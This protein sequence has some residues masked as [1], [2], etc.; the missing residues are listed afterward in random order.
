MFHLLRASVWIAL[1][2]LLLPGPGG[3]LARA[4][5]TC[6]AAG[7][8]PP[9][10]GAGVCAYLDE[11]LGVAA[12][13]APVQAGN[14]VDLVTGNKY[15]AEPDLL[16]DA[17]PPQVLVR[18]Y[19]SLNPHTGALGAGWSH[20][21]E[22]R[23]AAV[24]AGGRD[25]LQVLQGDGRRLVFERVRSGGSRWRTP[26]PTDGELIGPGP[27][28]PRA[29]RT[30]HRA[31]GWALS[32]RTDGQ[33]A[34]LKKGDRPVLQLHY[35]AQ[36][37][38]SAVERPGAWRL[39]V[40]WIAHRLGPRLGAAHLGGKTV[41]WDYDPTGQLAA[42]HWPD[43]RTQHYRYEDLK[44]PLR[45]TSVWQS[46][47]GTGPAL[48]EVA[49]YAYDAQGRTLQTRDET[50]QTLHFD[51]TLPEQPGGEGRTRVT[52]GLGRRAEYRW[53][54]QR[55]R[56]RRQ[57]LEATGEACPDCSP[58]PRHYTYDA[59]G[60]LIGVRT[61]A[62]QAWMQRD[63]VGR[64]IS[65]SWQASDPRHPPWE[66]RIG[67]AGPGPLD[68]WAWLEQSSVAPGRVHRI[69]IE[70]DAQ[71]APVA[72][73]ETG[74]SPRPDATDARDWLLVR[75]RILL[76]KGVRVP[77]SAVGM[78]HAGHATDDS[79]GAPGSP[80]SWP[81]Q[82]EAFW[83]GHPV[84]LRLADGSV[85]ARGF[86]DLGRVVW[87]DAPGQARQWAA[88]DAAD[89]LIEHRPGDGS[90]QLHRRNEDG[91]R[92]ES[93]HE[94]AHER[95]LLGRYRWDKGRLVEARN[96]TV[97]LQYAYHHDGQL[98]AVTHRFSSLTSAPVLRWQA[99]L[100][101]EGTLLTE[102]LP[103]GR[104]IRYERRDGRVQ[105]IWIG[106]QR[107]E[108]SRLEVP[109]L[110]I[111]DLGRGTLP[112]RLRFAAGRL[113][114]AEGVGYPEDP[115]GRRAGKVALQAQ[116]LGFVRRFVYQDW[117]LRAELDGRG[118][119]RH[120]IWADDR[121][122]AWLEGNEVFTL[123]T[124]ERKAPVRAL[125][126]QG[127][128]VWSARYDR[129]GAAE[130]APGTQHEVPLR[131]PGQY[132]DAESGLHHNVFRTYDPQQ[133]HYLEADPLGVQSDWTG[134]QDLLRY[135]GGDPVGHA[136]PW[137]LARLTYFA[138]TTGAQ[139][140]V[141][142]RTQGFDRARWSFMVEDIAPVTLH[143]AV[144]PQPQPSGIGSLLFDPWGSFV[145][146]PAAAAFGPGNG[147]DALAFSSPSGREVFS[148]FSAHYGGAL[149]TTARF[150]VPAFDDRR[151][152]ALSRILSAVPE[153]RQACI[154]R[155]LRGL[156]AFLPSPLGD[157]ITPNESAD[158][159]NRLL[160]CRSQTSLPVTYQDEVERFRV[161][162]L[163]AAAELQES[164]GRTLNDA[165][166]AQDGCA[167]RT[168]VTVNGRVYRASYGR[169]QFTVT[170]F[171]AE[172]SR[173]ALRPDDPD[174]T[175]LRNAVGLDAPI[176][177]N[178][179]PA[180]VRDA[181][182]L[183][184][185]RVEATY[186]L[187][188]SLR[189]TYGSG[190]SVDQAGAIW[191]SLTEERRQAFTR[192]TGLG[193]TGFIDLLGY[194]PTGKGGLT[195]E[196][197]RHA[198]AASAT[199]TVVWTGPQ[200]LTSFDHWLTRL[201]GSRDPYDHVSRAFLRDNLRRVQAAPSLAG[202]FENPHPAGSTAWLEKQK[203]IELDLAQRVA[204]LHN[205]GRMDLATD[206]NLAGWLARQPSQGISRYV[207]EFTAQ[208]NAGNWD[209]LRCAP[210][211]APGRALQLAD[212]AAS[213]ERSAGR[214]NQSRSA[215][216]GKGLLER[217]TGGSR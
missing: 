113:I 140:E 135:A 166:G 32:F 97:S 69:E 11:A 100:N 128:T 109:S 38:L 159:G 82:A 31:G 180:R 55:F 93:W 62:G 41:R 206:P 9:G 131:L 195:E 18:H 129:H 15:R 111:P 158:G 70:R 13:G 106:E 40:E 168:A 136:D 2:C 34:A 89:R 198:L 183:A 132:F 68:P 71:G 65:L 16:L 28:S 147:L 75:R 122:V 56:H 29:I 24:R 83:R 162:R 153:D 207:R 110:L 130:I 77:D 154:A 181:L 61:E 4:Q 96:N 171:L 33:A 45:L 99:S 114:E 165:C 46:I 204:V 172:L 178:G 10:G 21:F 182:A 190:L 177:L 194:A 116:A 151:A 142:G 51:W 188:P 44:D 197:G 36:G 199:A 101:L 35:D 205:A 170:T 108:V 50:G 187:W 3:G 5:A 60:R 74:W 148:A 7:G 169:T 213:F 43:G 120:W 81:P 58:T 19:N 63:A 185:K 87:I 86:D 47:R 133:G 163:Q 139:G 152:A 73:N 12:S 156:P 23:V 8:P 72:L 54:Y 214:S 144:P 42:T 157:P 64:P 22:T 39:R 105:V 98:A 208:N 174:A 66:G 79:R 201:Y 27:E 121:P 14:P 1:T 20:S 164:P 143:G 210:G 215:T 67:Y 202:R 107:V 25:T 167:A 146:G 176:Q 184:R 119:V 49:R 112:G 125:D 103:E 59:A 150:T 193:R 196:E 209:A 76:A 217:L 102:T 30:W 57:L 78:P 117:R 212:L 85:F 26:D 84:R 6:G 48:R 17:R 94:D 115:H 200:G 123:I 179:E 216:A 92:I 192:D 80:P 124:D 160:A 161:E 37:R 137:G 104:I 189:R 203:A 127:R 52:D 191:A 138:L 95:R 186:R 155:A 134:A 141:L 211:L 88:Y 118:R 145:T 53:V 91:L 175:A 149:T 126:A 173:L 90:R